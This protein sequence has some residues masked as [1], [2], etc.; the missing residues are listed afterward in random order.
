MLRHDSQT[1]ERLLWTLGGLLNLLKCAYYILA[2]KY[3]AEGRPSLI[4]KDNLPTIFLSSGDLPGSAPV[5]Q[6][7]FDETHRY[8]G[9]L[10]AADM[11]MKDS[12]QAL[13]KT[14][15]TFAASI[16]CSNLF[17]TGLLDR[18]FCGV[19]SLRDV[20]PPRH[21][22]VEEKHAADPIAGH[23]SLSDE[24]RIQQEHRP[25]RGVWT[26]DPRQPWLSRPFCGTRHQPSPTAA[27]SPGRRLPA[28][29]TLPNYNRLVAI[30]DGSVLPPPRTSQHHPPSPRG[31]LVVGAPPVPR[32]P[33]CLH[34]HRR[35]GHKA[36][37]DA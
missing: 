35:T 3:D 33:P 26:F 2:W 6:L 36:T 11:Q 20:Y 21:S 15:Q 10:L 4:P 29:Q 23:Q 25:S 16:L 13:F 31:T 24:S 22:P 17:E 27:P 14:S 19:R 37:R 8:L 12:F 5:T 34:P 30:S 1:W 7:N 9:N 18:V 32:G 28:R